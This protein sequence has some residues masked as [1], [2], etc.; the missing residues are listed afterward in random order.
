[1]TPEGV[2]GNPVLGELLTLIYQKIV[3]S[4]SSAIPRQKILSVEAEIFSARS[5]VL[6]GSDFANSTDQDHG[7]WYPT[8]RQGRLRAVGGFHHTQHWGL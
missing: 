2:A 4:A 3:M 7:V 8:W 6:A 1:M 5:P